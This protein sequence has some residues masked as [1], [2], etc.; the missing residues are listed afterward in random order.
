MTLFDRTEKSIG[1]AI[2]GSTGSVGRQALDVVSALRPRFHVV[3]LAARKL[4]PALIDQIARFRPEIV[5]VA[6]TPIAAGHSIDNLITGADG[7]MAAATHNDAEIVIVATSGHMAIGPILSAIGRG[8]TIA[9]AN[10]E[11]LVCAGE[12]IVP[13]A[14]AHGTW[15]RPVDSEHSAIW[16]A[17]A[18]S[19]IDQVKRIIITASGGPFRSTPERDFAQLTVAQA[20]AHPTWSMGAKISVDSATLMNKGLEIVEAH[21]LFGLPYD[22]IE[23]LVHPESVIHSLVEFVDGGLIAQLG[24]PDMKV[25]IQYALTYPDRV[26][27]EDK[28]SLDL[29]AIGRLHFEEPDVTR[30]PALRLARDAGLAGRTYPTVLSAADDEAVTAFLDGVIPFVDVPAVTESVLECHDAQPV[31]LESIFAADEWARAAAKNVI[32]KRRH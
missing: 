24:L 17:L 26:P 3:A 8:K 31:T 20:L 25:P 15:I 9:L 4:S 23:V 5:S 18:G 21:W 14:A 11:A 12:L 30:F 27:M 10:K 1:I 2:L 29:A 22:R 16:Q 32:A 6:E 13:L 7:L 19:S 28:P